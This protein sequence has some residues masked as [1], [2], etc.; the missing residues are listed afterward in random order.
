MTVY[1]VQL[2]RDEKL[3]GEELRVEAKTE[4]EAAEK[5]SGHVLYK[6]GAASSIRALVRASADSQTLFYER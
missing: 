4:K 3:D 6:Q 5:A 1:K 2:M